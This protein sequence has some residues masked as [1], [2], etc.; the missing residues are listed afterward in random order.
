L[1]RL[2]FDHRLERLADALLDSFD[3]AGPF[4]ERVVVVPSTGTG[5]WL[6]QRDAQRHGVSARLRPEFAGRWLWNTMRAVLDRLP[7]QSPFDPERVRWHCWRSRRLPRATISRCCESGWASADRSR[8]WRRAD[9]V[10]R[11][12]DATSLIGATASRCS[13]RAWAEGKAAHTGTALAALL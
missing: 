5:R 9:A 7:A 4:D 3:D 10:A 2:R 12:F 6:Q 1:L 11:A 13:E 8:D